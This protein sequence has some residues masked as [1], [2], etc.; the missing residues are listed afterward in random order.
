MFNIFNPWKGFPSANA[1]YLDNDFQRMRANGQLAFGTAQ[2]AYDA[3]SATGVATVIMVGKISSTESLDVTLTANYNSL[4]SWVGIN[5]KISQIRNIIGNNA[6]GNGYSITI[7]ITNVLFNSISSNYTGGGLFNGGNITI[8]SFGKSNINTISSTSFGNGNGGNITVTGSIV[9]STLITTRAINGGV[10]GNIDLGEESEVQ[11]ITTESIS[12]G[13][14]IIIRK[15]CKILGNISL[16]SFT[17]VA[18]NLTCEEDVTILGIVTAN[19]IFGTATFTIGHGS[20]LNKIVCLPGIKLLTNDVVFE[21]LAPADGLSIAA[22]TGDSV[23]RDTL[24]V[25]SIGSCIQDIDT[26]GAQFHNCIFIAKD[27]SFC[28]EASVPRA[29]TANNTLSKTDFDANLTVT[30]NNNLV[31]STLKSPLP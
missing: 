6:A 18:G 28:V 11:D 5:P 29:I 23:L 24:I 12:T 10:G 7:D 14:N 21:I 25:A 31:N 26:D 13:G 1:I 9:S 8:T 27:G 20:R 19:G 15:R 3:A 22:I 16:S 2:E 17:G 4:V 30:G